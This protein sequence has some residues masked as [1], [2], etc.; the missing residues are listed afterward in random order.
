MNKIIVTGPESSGKTTIIK[1]LAEYFNL[2]FNKEYARDYLSQIKRNYKQED[3]LIIAKKQFIEENNKQLLDTDLITIKIWS[4]YKYKKCDKWIIQKIKKQQKEQRLYLLCKPD[5]A[6]KKDVLR[7]NPNDRD[8]L[9]KIYQTEL[10]S[11]NH[12]YH[13]IENGNRLEKAINITSNWIV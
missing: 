1:K 2:S 10:D 7:E 11:L 12:S 6:W 8:E 5:I 3:L 13:I 9:F 4:N